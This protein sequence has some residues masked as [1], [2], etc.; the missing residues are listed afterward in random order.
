ML[1]IRIN[2][3]SLDL[4]PDTALTF[5]QNNPVFQQE[6][7]AEGYSYPID[8]PASDRNRIIFGFIDDLQSTTDFQDYPSE[9]IADNAP[10]KG[11]FSILKASQSRFTGSLYLGLFDKKVLDKSLKDLNLGGIRTIADMV[12]HANSLK[13]KDVDE[14]D[15]VF[16]PILNTKFYN[17]GNADRPDFIGTINNYQSGSFVNWSIETNT[18]DPM[19]PFD[20]ILNTNCLVPFPYLIYVLRQI[21]SELGKTLTGS[22]CYHAEMKKLTIYNTYALDE[23]R[24]ET[25]SELVGNIFS[26]TINLK[27]HVQDITCREFLNALIAK[28]NVAIN[29]TEAELQISFKSD[30]LNQL[31][32]DDYSDIVEDTFTIEPFRKTDTEGY[33]F[34]D[35]IDSN[36]DAIAEF[37]KIITTD[38]K[39]LNDVDETAALFLPATLDDIQFVIERNH[40][41]KA[42]KA[43]NTGTP[44]NHYQLY[45]G[46]FNAATY[47]VGRGDEKRESAISTLLMAKH[48]PTIQEF[49]EIA[50]FKLLP[51]ATQVGNSPVAEYQIGTDNEFSLRL[52]FYRGLQPTDVTYTNT[53]PLGTNNIYNAISDTD[54]AIGYISL[55]WGGLSGMYNQFHKKWLDLVAKSKAVNISL[56]ITPLQWAKFDWFKPKQIVNQ[57][58]IIERITF[59]IAANGMKKATARV[60]KR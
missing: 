32:D 13:T 21:A 58:C 51:I 24:E 26:E 36:D 29:V 55:Q 59:T 52:M 28:F 10:K 56:G 30:I 20:Y 48:I 54:G 15:Y 53:Y 37:S 17:E 9:L 43:G 60:L 39:V 2:G 49:P 27:N 7:G 31:N 45:E 33:T 5:E 35:D 38:G 11:V 47:K 57:S 25:T 6:V 44:L 12:T 40:Y 41:Y 4:Y 3:Q 22:F 14:A 42:F 23:I 8:I 19:S 16:F 34:T 18:D 1:D 46:A 50:D